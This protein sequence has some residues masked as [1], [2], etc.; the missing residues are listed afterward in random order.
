M[1]TLH[2]A[3]EN[4]DW[5]DNATVQKLRLS[6][7]SYFFVRLTVRLDEKNADNSR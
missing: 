3:A 4:D 6:S 5:S 1:V 7:L 2:D